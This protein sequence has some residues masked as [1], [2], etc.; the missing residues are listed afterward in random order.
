V[1]IAEILFLVTIGLALGSFLN[2]TIDRLPRGESLIRPP[3]RCDACHHRLSPLDLVPIISYVWL[4]GR[5]R[6]CKHRIPCR[7]PLVEGITAAGCGFIGYQYGL[8]PASAVLVLYLITIIHL[9]LVDLEHSLILNSVI[10]TA[11]VIVLATLPFSP[12]S[13]NLSL[14]EIYLQSLAGAG[15]GIG[16]MLLIYPVSKGRI[17]AGKVKLAA[18][19]GAMLGFPHIIAGLAVGLVCVGILAT[20]LLVP[21]LSG[22]SNAIPL[23]PV[24]LQK[25]DQVGEG[26]M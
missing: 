16:I 22:R 8:T 6:Y 3:S 26:V 13:Q 20:V 21:K 4:L 11:L 19:L 7:S 23:G 14:S 12:L 25:P 24:P 18:L 9:I 2:V 17:G 10:M 1:G 5:C 15:I